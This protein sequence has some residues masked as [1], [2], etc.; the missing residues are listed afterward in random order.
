MAEPFDEIRAALPEDPVRDAA[1]INVQA[2]AA[3]GEW[4]FSRLRVSDGFAVDLRDTIADLV[5]QIEM[6]V[7]ESFA[8]DPMVTY[9]PGVR[10]EPNQVG[11]GHGRATAFHDQLGGIRSRSRPSSGAPIRRSSP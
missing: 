5:T 3:E 6:E 9:E 4:N 1:V 7:E 11:L 2:G 8:V 10:F